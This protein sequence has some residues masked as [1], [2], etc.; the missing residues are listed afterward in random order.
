MI[1]RA[2]I[3][4]HSVAESEGPSPSAPPTVLYHLKVSCRHSGGQAEGW[5][6]QRKV[7]DFKL[8]H[9]LVEQQVLSFWDKGCVW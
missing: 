1:L 2:E 6:V 3:V 5:S 9:S 4:D 8:L 7:E